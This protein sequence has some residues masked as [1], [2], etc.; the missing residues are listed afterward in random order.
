MYEI[1]N[2]SSVSRLNLTFDNQNSVTIK[3]VGTNRPNGIKIS[4]A[5]NE[6]VGFWN[7]WYKSALMCI[8]ATTFGKEGFPYV[9]SL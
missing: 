8:N 6:N 2:E 7:V 1:R 3:K 9:Y 4:N 5:G